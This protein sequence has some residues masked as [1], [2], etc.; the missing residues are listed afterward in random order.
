[1]PRGFDV[2]LPMVSTYCARELHDPKVGWW[3]VAYTEF[4]AKM[5]GFLLVEVYDIFRLWCLSA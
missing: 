1:M 4:V 3:M 5:A 2:E